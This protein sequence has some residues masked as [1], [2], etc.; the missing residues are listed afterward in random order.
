VKPQERRRLTEVL[1][2]FRYAPLEPRPAGDEDSPHRALNNAALANFS[3]WVPA[4]GLYRCRRTRKGYEAVP[5]WR[6][7]T[8]GRPPEQRHCNLKIVPGGSKDFGADRGFT[9][10]ALVMEANGCDLDTTWKFLS[11]KLS[12]GET[13]DCVPGIAP[14][15]EIVPS[16]LFPAT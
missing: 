6:P 7:S 1:T 14:E 9:P 8:T 10:L 13:D 2:P 12:W 15:A 5:I 11:E 4:L 3:A 16:R